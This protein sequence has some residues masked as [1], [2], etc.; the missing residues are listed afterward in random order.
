MAD[1]QVEV[2]RRNDARPLMEGNELALIYF[3]SDKI[4]FSASVLQP[5]Q[6]SIR[7]PGHPGAHEVVYCMRGE[8]VIEIGDGQGQFVRLGTGDAALLYEG[9]PH[10]AFNASSEP[11]EMIW[12]AAP[13]LG[14]PLVYET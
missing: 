4:V 13:S 8:V 9:V 1:P 2:R 10:T 12:A 3:M 7:D 5:G 6:K 14:R 11:A